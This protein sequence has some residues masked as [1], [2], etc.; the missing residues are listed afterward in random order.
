APLAPSLAWLIAAQAV[1]FAGGATLA[2]DLGPVGSVFTN[3]RRL[4]TGYGS[5]A[6]PFMIAGPREALYV[7]A[8]FAVWPT[9][10]LVA[11]PG[12]AGLAQRAFDL[13][14]AL[15]VRE[16]AAAAAA[17]RPLCLVLVPLAV[18]VAKGALDVRLHLLYGPVLVVVAAL[19]LA[20]WLEARPRGRVL[21]AASAFLYVAATQTGAP[22]AW[23]VGFVGVGLLTAMLLRL[24][25]RLALLPGVAYA[26]AATALLGPLH[27]GRRWAWE[28]G[29]VAADVP[30]AVDTFPNADLQLVHCAEGRDGPPPMRSLLARAL[31]RHPDDRET[32]LAVAET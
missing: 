5:E 6:Q 12:L 15:R 32:V 9:L 22:A 7:Y 29:P 13:A 24:A 28:R 16:P 31:E 17:L 4:T 26:L 10:A 25:P 23:R 19:A 11:I 27:W 1:L 20:G 8:D 30:R 21:A 2:T 14:R 3:V 18:I